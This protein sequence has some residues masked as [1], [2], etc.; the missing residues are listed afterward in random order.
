MLG[1]TWKG[2]QELRQLGLI[3]RLPV[4]TGSQKIGNNTPIDRLDDPAFDSQHYFEPLDGRWAWKSIQE[5]Q[6]S[7]LR[8]TTKEIRS[9]QSELAISEGIFAEPQG[10]YAVAGLL[11]AGQEG[12]LQSDETIV[13]VVTGM[14][15]KDMQAAQ[16]ISEHYPGHHAVKRVGSLEESTPFLLV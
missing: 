15:L 8:V 2:F 5:S 7:L 11:K 10:A 3:D 16:E 4:V 6:G 14:G 13:C 12:M 1:G 9:A